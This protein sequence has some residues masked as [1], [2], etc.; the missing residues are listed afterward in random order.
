[1]TCLVALQVQCVHSEWLPGV[2]GISDAVSSVIGD[3]CPAEY[4]VLAPNGDHRR[5]YIKL[6]GRPWSK[7]AE[8]GADL[9]D[10]ICAENL[11]ISIVACLARAQFK[12]QVR[13][14]LTVAF[15]L[16]EIAGRNRW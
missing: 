7:G 12:L 3:Y 5:K 15:T 11:L 9:E 13:L 1:M 8:E 2:A 4:A 14:F 6:H 10:A 16:V